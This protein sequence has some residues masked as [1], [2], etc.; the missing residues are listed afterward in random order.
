MF[1]NKLVNELHR[2]P[3]TILW[4]GSTTNGARISSYGASSAGLQVL[5]IDS[6]AIGQQVRVCTL[7]RKKVFHATVTGEG[8]L[9]GGI[10]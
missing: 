8:T 7:D 6:A 1:I 2:S 10:E 9:T 3:F 5:V 4:A